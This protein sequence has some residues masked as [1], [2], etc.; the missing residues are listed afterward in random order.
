MLTFFFK[1]L[2]GNENLDGMAKEWFEIIFTRLEPIN[3]IMK[4]LDQRE[5]SGMAEWPVFQ[6]VD[7]DKGARA[8]NDTYWITSADRL[9]DETKLSPTYEGI[10]N[11]DFLVHQETCLQKQESSGKSLIV[12][13][14]EAQ[15]KKA[16]WTTLSTN[17]KFLQGED[18]NYLA[19]SIMISAAGESDS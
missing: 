9:C 4:K 10:R 11:S 16:Q 13:S 2:K 17:V 1:T 18:L 7:S 15:K 8:S 19:Q 3:G 6:E 12:D 5:E 14:I